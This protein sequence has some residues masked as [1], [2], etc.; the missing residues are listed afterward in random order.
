MKLLLEALAGACSLIF[1]LPPPSYSVRSRPSVL[2]RW[3]NRLVSPKQVC[4]GTIQSGGLAKYELRYIQDLAQKRK[5]FVRILQC[6]TWHGYALRFVL[7]EDV[8]CPC[9][10][11]IQT[12]ELVGPRS[13]DMRE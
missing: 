6:R 4:L 8:D 9:G 13:E 3:Q 5:M 12:R 11:T 7:S 1:N 10:D 2:V